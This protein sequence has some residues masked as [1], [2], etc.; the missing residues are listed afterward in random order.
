MDK[1][2][3]VDPAAQHVDLLLQG[4]LVVTM[5]SA[6]QVFANGYIAI[7]AGKIVAVG[8]VS[9][10]GYTSTKTIDTADRIILPGF[11]N[12]HDHLV[13]VYVRG[14][15]RDRFIDTSPGSSQDPLSKPIREA[16]DEEAAYHGTRLALLELQKS[17]V[18]TTT[19]S[20][21]A[22]R[23]MEG[24]AD[25]T[26][27]A[28]KESG[29]RAMYCR[30]SHNRTTYVSPE[31]HDTIDSALVD[32]ERLHSKWASDRIEIAAEAHGLHRVEA[33]LLKALK[34][35]TRL[36]D[37]HFTMHISFSRDAAQHAV[38]RFGRPLML[39]LEEWGVL[40]NRFL[41]YHPVWVTDEEIAATA[42]CSAGVAYCPVDNMLIGCGA[43]PIAKLLAA[44][45]RVGLGVDQ[46]ND[47][48]NYFELMK[49]SILLQRVAGADKG[50]GTPELALELATLGGARALH[51][52]DFIGSIEP[53]KEADV[54]VLD[55]RRSMLNPFTGRLSNAVYAATPAEV[56][57]VFV[58]G[59]AVVAE[60]R[61]TRWDEEEV[62]Q[63][64]DASMHAILRRAGIDRTCWPV[65]SWPV[66]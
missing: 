61:H 58:G 57:H 22:Y 3:S 34:Q 36:H 33:G 8:K 63:A 50:F 32:L 31:K 62:I 56:E 40:D 49:L 41:G 24:R 59:D 30:A 9:E 29:I 39:L 12:S 14:L 6:R 28:M 4:G 23:G 35:W 51:R 46:P 53:G 52:E 19:D 45:V 16:V 66:M 17:G 26:L 43:A 18:T 55:G 42:R 25:G 1:Q 38:E 7:R 20:Q 21:P 54:V 5:N 44:D 2:A 65:T 47:G 15:G 37:A 10:C 13:G 11:V 27:R 64:V 48:H 60:G